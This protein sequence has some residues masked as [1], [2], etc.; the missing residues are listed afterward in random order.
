MSANIGEDRLV[1]FE[2]AHHMDGSSASSFSMVVDFKEWQVQHVELQPPSAT[3]HF[4]Q[5]ATEGGM[6]L[7]RAGP[8]MTLMEAAARGA[9]PNLTCVHLRE[10]YRELDVKVAGRKPQSEVA[11]L[12]AIIGHVLPALTAAEIQLL[13]AQR[14][15]GGKLAPLESDLTRPGVFD[16]TRHL[17]SSKDISLFDDLLHTHNKKCAAVAASRASS[18]GHPKVPDTLKGKLDC[19]PHM[20][21]EW[22]MQFVPQ[23]ACCTVTKECNWHFRWKISYVDKPLPPFMQTATWVDETEQASFQAFL[24]CL[25]WV[26]DVH[27]TQ[28]G[29]PCP[30]DLSA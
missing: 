11:L 5:T 2:F 17:V 30:W 12:A 28:T 29:E 3:T 23:V 6:L 8:Q 7:V 25:Q 20:S 10:L 4:P 16:R 15:K 14:G 18:S 13:I 21:Q 27:E 1:W 24:T 22:A 26:W 9:F 19:N